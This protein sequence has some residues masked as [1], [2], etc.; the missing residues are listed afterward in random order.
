[1]IARLGRRGFVGGAAAFSAALWLPCLARAAQAMGFD[2]ARHQIVL[3]EALGG[4]AHHALFF[5]K[6]ILEPE[7][8]FPD[9]ILV[10]EHRGF[11]SAGLGRLRHRYLLKTAVHYSLSPAGKAN[12]GQ[13]PRR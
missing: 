9:E 7:R 13:D 2:D 10:L 1:M 4:V 5:R 3:R 11:A 12:K 6:L 8:V